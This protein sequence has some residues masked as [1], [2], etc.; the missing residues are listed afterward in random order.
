[1]RYYPVRCASADR[2]ADR[3][4]P[5]GTCNMFDPECSSGSGG[6]SGSQGP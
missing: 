1:M 2:R 4:R 5:T 3:P 6:V